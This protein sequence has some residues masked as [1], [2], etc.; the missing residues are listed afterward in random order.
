MLTEGDRQML[1][2]QLSNIPFYVLKRQMC[3]L[4]KHLPIQGSCWIS[5]FY[6]GRRKIQGIVLRPPLE[7][8]LYLA[9]KLYS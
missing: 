6:K 9:A 1:S 2:K 3:N 8:S 5:E 4:T 7:L